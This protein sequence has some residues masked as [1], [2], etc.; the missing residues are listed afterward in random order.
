[1]SK[2]VKHLVH[3]HNA[4]RGEDVYFWFDPK[5]VYKRSMS[6]FGSMMDTLINR[7]LI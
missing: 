3:L 7:L 2:P 1:M 5:Y 6:W 4:T